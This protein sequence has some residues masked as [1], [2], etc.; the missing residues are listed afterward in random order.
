MKTEWD[1]DN[2]ESSYSGGL[3]T[4]PPAGKH[5]RCAAGQFYSRGAYTIFHH[6]LDE[7]ITFAF[8]SR[9]QKWHYRPGY[10]EKFYFQNMCD[11]KY[12]ENSCVLHIIQRIIKKF[13]FHYEICIFVS[14]M[15]LLEYIDHNNYNTLTIDIIQ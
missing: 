8:L 5:E 6:T 4:F 15:Y 14:L 1:I 3:R 7:N 12:R 13:K 11:T 9:E 2:I 10:D